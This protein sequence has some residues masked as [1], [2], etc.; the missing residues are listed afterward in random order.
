ML[1]GD[2]AELAHS[3]T[4]FASLV[5]QIRPFKQNSLNQNR[6]DILRRWLF[7]E[8]VGIISEICGEDVQSP[9]SKTPLS[10]RL[11]WALETV[12]VRAIAHGDL[13]ADT[14][15]YSALAL[16]C[17]LWIPPAALL[18][19]ASFPSRAGAL[20]AVSDTGGDFTDFA[21]MRRWLA[22]DLVS[23][24]TRDLNWPTPETSEIW[25]AF[26]ESGLDDRSKVWT[27]HSIVAHLSAPLEE[28]ESDAG[29]LQVLHD[30][31][32][33]QTWLY[34]DDMRRLGRLLQPF[35]HKPSGIV[36]VEG[37]DGTDR[38][39]LNYIGPDFNTLVIS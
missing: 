27:S 14:I 17:G 6:P 20:K 22:S 29:R 18:V 38:V 5:F 31:A 35:R 39:R 12:R 23:Q 21:E 4:E 7:G 25:R 8:M 24:M 13:A 30:D 34:T 32:E 10:Y 9:L 37:I 2:A 26:R 15:G 19:A 36:F 11:V 1:R 33:N 3:L 16:E 28:F